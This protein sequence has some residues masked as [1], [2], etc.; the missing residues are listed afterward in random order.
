MEQKHNILYSIF[1]IERKRNFATVF[2]LLKSYGE[3]K[4]MVCLD[5]SLKLNP[6]KK[7]KTSKEICVTTTMQVKL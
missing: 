5:F 6:L 4:P 2:M 7:D 3:E 1:Y